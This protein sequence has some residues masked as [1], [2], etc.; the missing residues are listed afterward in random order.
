MTAS[1]QPEVESAD[2]EHG[3][4]NCMAAK[5]YNAATKK[6]VEAHRS[7]VLAMADQAA[8]ALDISRKG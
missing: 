6:F 8:D 1:R 2:T 3:E 7:E 5:K 4:S